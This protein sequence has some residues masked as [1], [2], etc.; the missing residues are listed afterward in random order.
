[1]DVFNAFLNGE[2]EEEVYMQQPEGFERGGRDIV[3][4]LHKALYGL[5]QASW[6]WKIKLARILCSELGFQAIYSDSSIY[7]FQRDDLRVLLPVFVDDCTFA[8]NSA[9]L[10][11]DLAA[12]LAKH[13][14]LRDLGETTFLLG[15]QITRN[16]AKRCMELSQRQYILDIL[17]RFNM[18]DCNAVTTPMAPGTRLSASDSPQS[19][20]ERTHMRPIPYGNAVGSL[21][22][23]ATTTRPDISFTVSSLCRFIAN[24]GVKHWKAVH[25]L[26]RYL[27]GTLNLKLV[28]Q[29][30]RFDSKYI[31]STFTDSDHAGNPDNGRSTGGYL[32]RIE[33]GAVSWISKLQTLTA[34]SSTEAEYIAAVGAGKEILWM[35]GLLSEF[36]YTLPNPS[37]LHMDT[38]SAI[39]VS[40]NPEHHGRMKQLDL[41][42]F[43]LRDEVEA[44]R[45]APKFIGTKEMPAD[46]L[47]KALPR[48]SVVRCREM[49]GLEE[50]K[51]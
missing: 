30:D 21:L 4:H 38:Q 26:L 24:P 13:F 10:L 35:R 22:Y 42:F 32:V 45:I 34:L 44:R 49:L 8:S 31:F 20:E 27:Q 43:W 39:S 11:D 41:R 40:K 1:V 17:S 3:C 14:K 29:G 16:R 6:T 5:K 28:Y 23:L 37:V 7:V 2:L 19:D 12:R 50:I 36:G 25:H 15:I 51:T 48:G 9:A 33:G 47:T 18:T 46:I